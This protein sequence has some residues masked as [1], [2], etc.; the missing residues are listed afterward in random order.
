MAVGRVGQVAR[1][2]KARV[3]SAVGLLLVTVLLAGCGGLADVGHAAEG[4]SRYQPIRYGPADVP[5]GRPERGSRVMRSTY[6]CGACHVVPGVTGAEGMVGPPLTSWARRVYVAG[7][8]PNTPENLVLWI[9]HPQAV[10]PG[11]AM[12]DLGVNEEDARDIA[13]YLYTLK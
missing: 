13:A 6:G 1:R 2:H 5:G 9:R 8:L 11:T 7:N 12:P 4:G 3:L 10:E